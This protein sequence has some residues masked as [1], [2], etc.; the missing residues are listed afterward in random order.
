MYKNDRRMFDRFEV[1]FST[2]IKPLGIQESSWVRESNFAQCCD[3]SAGG[4]GLFTEEELMPQTKLELWLGIPNG[5]SPL[6][7]IGRVVW[8][9][10]V[11]ENKWHFGLEFQTVDFMGLRRIFDILTQKG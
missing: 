5:H 4:V 10:Q 8:S 11:R 7:G 2:E 3:V 6:K 1:D 9:R